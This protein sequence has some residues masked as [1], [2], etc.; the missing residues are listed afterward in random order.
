[1]RLRIL[2]VDVE[3]DMG[4]GPLDLRHDAGQRDR[5]V[6]V[7]LRG[8]RMVSFG[9]ARENHGG[10]KNDAGQSTYGHDSL[11][12]HRVSDMRILT[13]FVGAHCQLMSTARRTAP[14]VR[15]CCPDRNTT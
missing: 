14:P 6:R 10:S 5:L 2:H 4:I 3:P 15:T 9:R 13:Q 12:V 1:A 8:K 7:E 11:S